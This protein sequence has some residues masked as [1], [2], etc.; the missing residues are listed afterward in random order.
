MATY[1]P[2]I[3]NC[4]ILLG[5]TTGSKSVSKKLGLKSTASA[6]K[7]S[8]IYKANLSNLISV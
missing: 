1:L 8:N 7:S 5:N 4:G 6:F 3:N 2:L